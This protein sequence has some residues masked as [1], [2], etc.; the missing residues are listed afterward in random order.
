MLALA[1]DC[2]GGLAE[3]YVKEPSSACADTADTGRPVPSCSLF[4]HRTPVWGQAVRAADPVK[5]AEHV[6]GYA[7]VD[8]LAVLKLVVTWLQEIK[9]E[10]KR[11]K[12]FK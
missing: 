2:S 11:K 1:I 3:E 9:K 5:N 4:Q 10:K 7:V 12:R 8:E 6:R